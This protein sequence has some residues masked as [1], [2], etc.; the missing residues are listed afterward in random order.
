MTAPPAAPAR[1]WGADDRGR[2]DALFAAEAR[3]HAARAAGALLDV[4]RDVER[5]AAP[6]RALD[7]AF[8]SVHTIKGLAAA[9]EHAG[10]AQLA[11]ALEDALA[12]LRDGASAGATPAWGSVPAA[13]PALLLD[14]ADALHDAVEAA[15]AGAPADGARSTEQL[16]ARLQA[17]A[18]DVPR[19]PVATR[20]T[21][22]A[23]EP[24][25]VGA[26]A[27]TVR[28]H[29]RLAA[30]AAL[31]AARAM[32]VL[33]RAGELGLVT[34]VTPPAPRWQ[35][36]GFDGAFAFDLPSTV[37]RG[38]IERAVRL[39]GEVAEVTIAECAPPI[40]FSSG[41]AAVAEP[42]GDVRHGGGRPAGRSAPGVRL[43]AARL[44]ALL[45]LVGELGVA[46]TRLAAAAARTG[47][48]ALAAA[49]GDVGRVAAALQEEVIACRLVPLDELFARLPRIV[50]EAART[51]GREVAL[52]LDGGE[53]AID[54][55]IMDGLAEPIGHLLRNAVAH[56]VEP[57]ER[58]A[59]AGKPPTGRVAVRAWRERDAVLLAVADDGGG[60]DRE[61]VLR[62]AAERDGGG[63]G[64][65]A[66]AAPLD[67]A[68]LLRLLSAPG[69]STAP[70]VTAVSGRGVGLDA[71]LAAVRRLGGTL[72]LRTAP[73]LGTTFTLRLPLTLAVV[74][75]LVVRDAGL[76]WAVPVAQL[77]ET[78]DLAPAHLADA[79]AVGDP[80]AAAPA[81]GEAAHLVSRGAAVALRSLHAVAHAS[82][83]PGGTTGTGAPG[84][85][86]P[87]ASPAAASVGAPS[88]EGE[89]LVVESEGV[90][91]ALRVDAVI[92]EREVVVKPLPPVR[93]A[94]RIWSGGTILEDGGVAPILDVPS[95]LR[96]Q[97]A[98]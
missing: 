13:T 28:V 68:G 75:V 48:R 73:G 88:P 3:E 52:A 74:R 26:L 16:V 91:V 43:D 45:D 42:L 89:A 50:R 39:A 83:T 32:I 62:R 15:I 17:A 72:A 63:A 79:A 27:G 24:R 97:S 61:A 8:R 94:L 18:G 64:E 66:A 67:D 6:A 54:R 80:R 57:A 82:A 95:F 31:P 22:P 11:H 33:R 12:A 85:G 19:A 59:A 41:V 90:A 7:A 9:M 78:L 58:R 60:V 4:Q 92:G 1:G 81:A 21:D 29:V 98:R 65:G 35:E 34:R 25:E 77:R 10:V 96:L 76:T 37:E 14:A 56:G 71:A 55:A 2:W 93:G 69:L 51:S 46:R 87:A 40:P 86:R 47:D 44:D 84:A 20:E 36:D 49:V 38:S 5:G 23:G 70:R 30:T 53:V